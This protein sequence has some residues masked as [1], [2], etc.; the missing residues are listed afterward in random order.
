MRTKLAMKNMVF[1]LLLELA[2]AI[3]GIIVPRFF[4]A[5][6]GSAVNGLVTSINQF[7][8]YMTLVEAGWYCCTL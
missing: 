1:S 2:T 5:L 7:I 8:T 6:Y 3:S 4:T